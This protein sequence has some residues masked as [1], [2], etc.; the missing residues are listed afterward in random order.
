[1][2]KPIP[3]VLLCA[4]LQF[5]L[6]WWGFSAIWGPGQKVGPS[7]IQPLT[8]GVILAVPFLG[9][10][11][12]WLPAECRMLPRVAKQLV[13]HLKSQSAQITPPKRAAPRVRNELV[14]E[15][16]HQRTSEDLWGSSRGSDHRSGWCIVGHLASYLM[17][18]SSQRVLRPSLAAEREK[19]IKATEK[20]ATESWLCILMHAWEW[21]ALVWRQKCNRCS[22]LNTNA[23]L[24]DNN[25]RRWW[26]H[27]LSS[28]HNL[29]ESCT[30]SKKKQA[31]NTLKM[32]A[33][34]DSNS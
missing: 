8:T 15:I 4:L 28:G 19:R 13:K 31:D 12:Y 5:P 24:R 22:G 17:I 3:T 14:H 25:K 9:C 1:M 10:Q 21:N 18:A 30:L 2:W 26:G 11:E 7:L 33:A 6:L 32:A 29:W 34:K 20:R 16:K 27:G 23:D